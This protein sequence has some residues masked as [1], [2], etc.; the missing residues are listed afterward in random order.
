MMPFVSFIPPQPVVEA[1][2]VVFIATREQ[3]T[4]MAEIFDPKSSF[5]LLSNETSDHTFLETQLFKPKKCA[6]CGDLIWGLKKQAFRCA[7]VTC[8][9]VLH[10]FET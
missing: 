7:G 4:K 3:M 5:Q 6:Y 1:V 8:A 10:L 2:L 9:I